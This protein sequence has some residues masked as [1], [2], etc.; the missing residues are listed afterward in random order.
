MDLSLLQ[1]KVE[2]SKLLTETERSYWTENLP[3]MNEQQIQKLDQIL[4]EA[5]GLPW[6][7]NMQTFMTLMK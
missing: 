3:T 5:D 7:R 4:T 2:T 6:Q 1:K